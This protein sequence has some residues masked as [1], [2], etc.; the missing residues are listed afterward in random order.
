MEDFIGSHPLLFSAMALAVSAGIELL[1]AWPEFMPLGH[2][3]GEVA[4]NLGYGIAAACV[5]NWIIVEIPAKREARRILDSYWWN[6]NEMALSGAMLL[7]QYRQMAPKGEYNTQ[8][9]TGMKDFLKTIPLIPSQTS[10]QGTTVKS[11]PELW[12]LSDPFAHTTLIEYVE[13]QGAVISPFLHRLDPG[14]ADCAIELMHF[15]QR[16]NGLRP[17]FRPPGSLEQEFLHIWEFVRHSRRL[18]QALLTHYPEHE[19]R[20]PTILPLSP[21]QPVHQ[22]VD[23]DL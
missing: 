10:M 3:I 23:A 15:R 12:V 8:T 2:E 22:I 17:V 9:E 7:A 18:R 4:R 16:M 14:V 11:G 1:Q 13:G 21:D 20:V 19:L 5:F 6:L